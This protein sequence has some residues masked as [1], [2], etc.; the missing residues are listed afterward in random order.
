MST[1]PNAIRNFHALF[2]KHGE[3]RTP[4]TAVEGERVQASGP[5]YG[6]NEGALQRKI[7][8]RKSVVV[9]MRPVFRGPLRPP[10][11]SFSGV[12]GMIH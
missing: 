11:L 9:K 2:E 1:N 8:R 7:D 5:R 3:V 12:G 10:I 4:L 6:R